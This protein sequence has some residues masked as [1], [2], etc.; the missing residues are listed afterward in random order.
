MSITFMCIV[1]C[2]HSFANPGETVK[3]L[4]T[5]TTND[6]CCFEMSHKLMFKHL[7]INEETF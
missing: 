6:C 2:I 7:S 4:K 5:P 3:G 1:I